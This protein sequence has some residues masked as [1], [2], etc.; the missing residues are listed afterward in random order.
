M[1]LYT[2]VEDENATLLAR[3]DVI[4]TNYN[5]LYDEME[6]LKRQLV[7]EKERR[8]QLEAS[9]LRETLINLEVC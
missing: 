1:I 9:H 4:G 7:I 2:Q 5:T 6:E 8:V 3:I